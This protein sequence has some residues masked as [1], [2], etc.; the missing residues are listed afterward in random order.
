MKKKFDFPSELEDIKSRN[1]KNKNETYL[2]ELQKFLDKA[3][4]IK[5]E[6]LKFSVIS[7]MIKCDSV[8]T[9][10][11]EETIKKCILRKIKYK[12]D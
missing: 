8:L 3:D 12:I 11:C 2:F 7:Q 5:D 10:I 9:D 1:W 4:C 6:E